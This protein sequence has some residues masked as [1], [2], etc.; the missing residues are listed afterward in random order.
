MS[1]AVWSFQRFLL[2][3]RPLTWHIQFGSACI[4]FVP[5]SLRIKLSTFFF[6]FTVSPFHPPLGIGGRKKKTQNKLSWLCWLVINEPT[7]W[8]L[9]KEMYA[10]TM[11]GGWEAVCST[12]SASIF[13]DVDFPRRWK[14]SAIT[15]QGAAVARFE[16]QNPWNVS[17]VGRRS[18]W[19]QYESI[20]IRA[21][22]RVISCYLNGE[23]E[24]KHTYK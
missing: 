11:H 17:L 19:N 12:S 20:F 21:P 22:T 13:N 8:Y 5:S 7:G 23:A 6:F 3:Y 9:C 10:N 1:S 16:A 18:S 24:Q 14:R 2:V 4:N 15:L